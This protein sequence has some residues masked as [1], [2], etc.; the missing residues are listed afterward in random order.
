MILP[1]RKKQ[2]GVYS[3]EFA[4]VGLVF[5]TLL[6]MVL[7]VGRLFFVWN[8]LSEASR[9]GAR[10][11][12]VCNFNRIDRIALDEMKQVALFNNATL[13]PA[14][15]TANLKIEYLTFNGDAAADFSEIDLV[16]ATIIN[17]QHKF[18]VPGLTK[19]LNSPSFS[20]ILPR[21]SLGVSRNARTDCEP[22]A[23]L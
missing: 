3:V 6:F 2:K 17:Y 16:R 4:L 23:P 18:M 15:T 22:I 12:S 1:G 9:R 8:V 7:E 11:A 13:V 19:T 5:F 14:L 21:E 20:T 10:L